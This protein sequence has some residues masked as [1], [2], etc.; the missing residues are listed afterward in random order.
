M[1]KMGTTFNKHTSNHFLWNYIFYIYCLKGKDATDFTGM[2]YDITT[3]MESEDVTWFPDNGE[4]DMSG[5]IEELVQELRT[6]LHSLKDN[7]LILLDKGN[8]SVQLLTKG[9]TNAIAKNNDLKQLTNAKTQQE[10]RSN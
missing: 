9:I 10:E 3:K 7:S 1:E 8:S 6:N 2:E 5:E 4:K